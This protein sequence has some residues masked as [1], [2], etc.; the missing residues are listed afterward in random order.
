MV[1]GII[2][3]PHVP[4]TAGSTLPTSDTVQPP[5]AGPLGTAHIP[6][7]EAMN[8]CVPGIGTR[9]PGQLRGK[10]AEQVEEGPGKD[11]DVVDVQIGLND[12]RCQT[13]AFR[14]G[15][16]G[17]KKTRASKRSMSV[18]K[19]Y[20]E[21]ASWIRVLSAAQGEPRLVYCPEKPFAAY[22]SE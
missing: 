12:H 8:T 10:G 16:G 6:G 7:A 9:R 17:A 11:D 15:Y 19:S 5:Q 2:P 22:F 13:N 14:V 20:L 1:H 4:H 21:A 18:Q 3:P